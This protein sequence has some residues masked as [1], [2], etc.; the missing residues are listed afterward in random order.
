V[1]P[2]RLVFTWRNVNFADDES[3]DVEVLFGASA[4]YAYGLH[5]ASLRAASTTTSG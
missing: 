1:T 2:S 3:T 4:P 5:P